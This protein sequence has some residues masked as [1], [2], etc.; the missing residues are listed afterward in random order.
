MVEAEVWREEVLAMKTT[1]RQPAWPAAPKFMA[2]S[3][4]SL[5]LLWHPSA[6]R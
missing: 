4:A 6:S 5:P 3:V 1:V 2:D